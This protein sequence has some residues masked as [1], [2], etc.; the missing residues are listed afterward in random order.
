M[1]SFGGGTRLCRRVV[2]RLQ[3]QAYTACFCLEL[4]LCTPANLIQLL[5][6]RRGIVAAPV[7]AIMG[8]RRPQPSP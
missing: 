1:V 3:T 8:R 2:L 7:A 6:G 4:P 5:Y